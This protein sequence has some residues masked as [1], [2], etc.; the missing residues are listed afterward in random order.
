[1][2]NRSRFKLET[3]LIH[4]SCSDL[5]TCID[6]LG[7]NQGRVLFRHRWTEEEKESFTI[8]AASLDEKGLAKE[9][10]VAL[11]IEKAIMSPQFLFTLNTQESANE[12]N[13]ARLS[14]LELATRIAL[15]LTG[16]PGRDVVERGRK[17]TT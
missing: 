14:D 6:A 9:D 7:D 3:I 2:L 15:V 4:F 1:M 13:V 12:D 10:I 5:G 16:R 11:L 17:W 8:L